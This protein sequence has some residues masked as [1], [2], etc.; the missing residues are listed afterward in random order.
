MYPPSPVH[1]VTTEQFAGK[2]PEAYDYIAK[3][4]FT[5]ADMNKLLVWMQD[6][7]ADGNTA[8]VHFV[9]NHESLWTSWVS[10]GVGA[11]VKKAVAGM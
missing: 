6:N 8:A 11:K 7:Q 9:K 3:R 4:S 1:T 10:S 5:N 2:A